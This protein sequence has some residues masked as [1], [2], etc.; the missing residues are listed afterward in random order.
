MKNGQ[1]WDPGIEFLSM[2]VLQGR[3]AARAGTATRPRRLSL[4]VTLLHLFPSVFTSSQQIYIL[5]WC[6]Q[7]TGCAWSAIICR[8][9][10][11]SFSDQRQII[12]WL[13]CT[14]SPL[15]LHSWCCCVETMFGARKVDILNVFK[16]RILFSRSPDFF[17]SPEETSDSV[18]YRRYCFFHL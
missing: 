4:E 8:R 17:F 1:A 12:R 14:L 18:K 9:S 15:C 10:W 7:M 16:Q 11:H 13:V 5:Q 6:E 3:D 2:V